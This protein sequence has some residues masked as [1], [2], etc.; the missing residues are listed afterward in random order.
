MHSLECISL[1]KLCNVICTKKW[2]WCKHCK[3]TVLQYEASRFIYDKLNIKLGIH[4]TTN[5]VIAC[6]S[7][8][9]PA[10]FWMYFEFLSSWRS[11]RAL[12]QHFCWLVLHVWKPKLKP[13]VKGLQ[14]VPWSLKRLRWIYR[15]NLD[16][17]HFNTSV[18][19]PSSLWTVCWAFPGSECVWVWSSGSASPPHTGVQDWR[20]LQSSSSLLI[21]EEFSCCSLHHSSWDYRKNGLLV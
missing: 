13:A 21:V 19:C 10:H 15:I 5:D 11:V 14:L 1:G 2:C 8:V 3:P 18:C 12:G 6:I 7:I 16:T 4:K 17:K 20:L 9:L